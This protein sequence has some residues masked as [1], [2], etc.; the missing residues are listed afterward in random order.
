MRY[1]GRRI[2]VT[3][4]KGGV[5]KTTIVANLGV[6]LA[7]SGKKVVLIDADIGL[8]NLD[9]VLGLENRIVYDLVDVVEGTCK[10]RQALIRDKRFNN[11]CLLPASQARDKESITPEQMASICEE[12]SKEF[13][14]VIIDSPAGIDRGFKNAVSAAEEGIVVTT[15]EVSS[16]RDADRVIGLLEAY[17]IQEPYLVINRLK[18]EMV[19]K[20]NMLSVED[21]LEILGIKLLGVV[22]E[23]EIVVIATNKGESILLYEKTKS[24]KAFKD[25]VKRIEG[26][27]VPFKE[28]YSSNSFFNFIRNLFFKRGGK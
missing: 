15:A 6:G 18:P 5:G 4:G 16:I 14:Y 20:G 1:L 27:E 9:L 22:P 21:V 17:K 3:S 23:E 2:V 19:N 26:E 10:L 11:L 24:A 7:F 13:D 25:M 8:R 12:L 28:I